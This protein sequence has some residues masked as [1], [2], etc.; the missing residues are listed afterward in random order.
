MSRFG[1]QDAWSMPC[2]TL[3]LAC[4]ALKLSFSDFAR[5]IP[6][7]RQ[8]WL[9]CVS[10]RLA[11]FRRCRPPGSSQRNHREPTVTVPVGVGRLAC[12]P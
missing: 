12:W 6:R 10:G 7:R 4:A 2:A 5:K 1:E 3:D 8:G 9:G 11:L